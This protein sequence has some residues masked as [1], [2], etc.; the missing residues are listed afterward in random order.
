MFPDDSHEPTILLTEV[1]MQ[2]TERPEGDDEKLAGQ[3][4]SCA[5]GDKDAEVF[6]YRELERPV[7]I[8]V[9]RFLREGHPDLDDVVQEAL[10]A[11]LDYIRKKGGFEGDLVRF[12]VTVARNRCRN[13]LNA[14]KRHPTVSIEPLADWIANPER[15]PLDLLEA[16]EV[17]RI[18]QEALDR[19]DRICRIILRS[20]YIEG[21]SI[22]TIQKKTGLQTVQGVYYRR[23][24][25]LDQI[26]G[27]LRKRLAV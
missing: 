11:T 3:I 16:K 24:V 18:L 17:G 15:S 25:C 27:I 4:R 10:L 5:A 1:T 23:S 6:L 22:R 8:S 20:F 2:P 26:A 13:L 21:R 12:A 19:L 7:R 14:R 9:I